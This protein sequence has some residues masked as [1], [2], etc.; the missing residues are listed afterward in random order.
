M[1]SVMGSLD[2]ISWDRLAAESAVTYPCPAP[3]AAGEAIIFGDGFPTGNG[4]AR[5]VPTELVPPDETPDEDYPFILTTGRQLEHWHTGALTRR[6]HVLDV[7]EPEAVASLSPP[8]LQRL[9]LSPG[10]RV[11][12]ETRRGQIELTARADP[13]VPDGVVFV[14]FCYAEAPAN[15]LT[16]PALDPFGKIP[17]FKFCA[18]RV[19][20]AGPA[21]A[22]R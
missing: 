4:R 22:E 16:N 6:S 19:A 2:N 17:E 14:P 21:P 1:Q 15:A 8:A 9:G 20:A 11:R 10:A 5:L 18:A 13:A 12:I 7:L 3:D